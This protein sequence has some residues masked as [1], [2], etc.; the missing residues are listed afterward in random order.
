MAEYTIR[1]PD[2]DEIVHRALASHRPRPH[3]DLDVLGSLIEK[4]DAPGQ[5]ETATNDEGESV[6]TGRTVMS[7]P[8]A[9]IDLTDDEATLL[10]GIIR[11]ALRRVDARRAVE[12]RY[13][14]G[15]LKATEEAAAT[16]ARAAQLDERIRE[17]KDELRRLA[18]EERETVQRVENLRSREARATEGAEA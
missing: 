16:N 5:A 8:E 11:Q 3:E 9:S 17:K 7:Q 10:H 2:Y 18:I 12:L 13:L 6:E 14:V 15:P 1:K 4:L